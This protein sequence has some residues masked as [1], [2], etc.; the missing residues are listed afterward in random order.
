MVRVLV[1]GSPLIGLCFLVGCAAPGTSNLDYAAPTLHSVEN[2]R[3]IDRPFD[4]VWDSLVERLAKS[5]FVIN[6]IEKESRIINVSIATKTPELYV[7]CGRSHRT[8]ERG[9]ERLSFDY[10][11]AAASSYKA[12]SVS[13]LNPVTLYVERRT[14]LDGRVNIYVAPRGDTQTLVTVN[15]RYVLTASMG[16]T[17]EA[18]SPLGVPAGSGAIPASSMT[19]SFDTAVPGTENWGDAKEPLRITCCCT[20]ELERQILAMAD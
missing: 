18:E 11:V 6:N 5:F 17:Y 9:R 3:L 14:S 13:G 12:A 7:D 15:V 8:Y 10:D 19:V 2:E 1:L 16:G 20:G 4:E